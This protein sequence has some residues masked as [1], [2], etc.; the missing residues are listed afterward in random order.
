M[1]TLILLIAT[2][3][4]LTWT[5]HAMSLQPTSEIITAENI[6]QLQSVQTIDFADTDIPYDTGWFAVN[7]NA[8]RI[9]TVSQDQ[10][11]ILWDDVGNIIASYEFDNPNDD[12]IRLADV[13][14]A[15]ESDLF[16]AIYIAPPGYHLNYY[17]EADGL[18]ASLAIETEFDQPTTL[19]LDGDTAWAE[20]ATPDLADTFVLRFPSPDEIETDS[21]LTAGDLFSIPYAPYNDPEALVRIG[22]ILPPTAVTTSPEG[23]V[24]LWDLQGGDI[25]AEA[26]VEAGPAVF[27]QINS[28][29]THLAWRDPM[30]EALHLLDFA[31]GESIF[32]DELGGAYVQYF[33]L[34][35]NA[36][37][38]FAVNIGF[39]PTVIVWNVASGDRMNLGS[40]RQCSRIPD[41]VR[42][43]ADGTSLVIGCDTGL[44]IWRTEN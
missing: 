2:F 23:L 8:T 6:T 28:S 11:L 24:K 12:P 29:A 16:A 10:T 34:S 27:G 42:L 32:V 43:S 31:S 41:M 15:T 39:E 38:I 22:R 13:T 37:L 7:H 36:D 17:T 3:L 21:I 9:A 30:S 4:I 5:W 26:Q 1:R 19:W 18:V 20:I 35:Y 33:E 44:D 40:Y 25:L 14:F